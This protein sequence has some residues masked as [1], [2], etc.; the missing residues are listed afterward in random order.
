VGKVVRL[1]AKGGKKDPS[2][3]SF[4]LSSAWKGGWVKV[5]EAVP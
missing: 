2:S 1:A 4:D 3:P 5:G